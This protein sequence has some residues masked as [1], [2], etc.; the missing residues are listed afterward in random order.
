MTPSLTIFAAALATEGLL[1]IVAYIFA[2][3][4]S[5]WPFWNASFTNLIIGVLLALPLLVMN[6]LIW[7]AT[8]SHPD[9]VYARFS[10]QIVVPLCKQVSPPLALFLAL[11]SGFGEEIFF[12]GVANIIAIEHAGPL[13]AALATSV[14]FAYVHFIGNV[15]R[16]GGM[17]PLYTVVGLYI[18]CAWLLT[19]SLFVAFILHA[20]Y[21]FLAILWVRQMAASRARA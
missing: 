6:H 5:A 19:N 3:L 13:G 7:K 17:I 15:S 4:F 12:R 18:W 10:R 9:S 8:L 20:S 2:G 16:F 11:A 21:N 1:I 14:V